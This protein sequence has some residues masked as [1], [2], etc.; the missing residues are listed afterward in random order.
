MQALVLTAPHQFEVADVTKP[1]PVRENEVLCRV[2]AI[3]I[4]GT[5]AEIIEGTFQG[6]W[7]KAYPFIPGHEWSG[8]VL[9]AGEGAGGVG[10][11]PRTPGA[12]TAPSGCGHFRMCRT[13]PHN[14]CLHYRPAEL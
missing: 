12:G 6:R 11:A 13:R 1:G 10:F 7:P 2:K 4:C 8:E 5:D 9:E 14:P 3:A